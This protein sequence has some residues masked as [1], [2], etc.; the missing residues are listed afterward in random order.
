M[1]VDLDD[2]IKRDHT[3]N[4]KKSWNTTMDTLYTGIRYRNFQYKPGNLAKMF[5]GIP[6]YQKKLYTTENSRHNS[7]TDFND[8]F[9]QTV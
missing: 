8:L 7:L 6:V 3:S 1:D 9:R 2:F 4:F 5:S